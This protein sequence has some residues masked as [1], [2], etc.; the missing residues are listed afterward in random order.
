MDDY[1]LIQWRYRKPSPLLFNYWRLHGVYYGGGTLTTQLSED[2]VRDELPKV[3]MNP[4]VEFKIIHVI[5]TEVAP[6]RF[7]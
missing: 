3:K 7:L 5:H 2:Q 6:E 1:Y 4:E